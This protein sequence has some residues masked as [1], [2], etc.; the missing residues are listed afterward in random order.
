MLAAGLSV[1]SEPLCLCKRLPDKRAPK[2]EATVAVARRVLDCLVTAD[3]TTTGSS[4][5]THAIRRCQ[6]KLEQRI[7]IAERGREQA[8]NRWSRNR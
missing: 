7:A 6:E 1:D 5:K 8:S 2:F 3:V 4:E